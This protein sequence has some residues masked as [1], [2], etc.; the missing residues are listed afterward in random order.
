MK[1]ILLPVDFSDTC[2]NT[3]KYAADLS[4]AI[5]VDRIIL[6][7]SYYVSIYEQILPSADFVQVSAE[8]IQDNRQ[9]EEQQLLTISKQLLQKCNPGI[10]IKIASSNEPLLRAMHQ[11][12]TDEKPD[13]V[14]LGTDSSLV[15]ESHV[16]QQVVAIAKISPVPVLIVPCNAQYQAVEYALVPC[17]FA[18]VTRLNILKDL[19][20][21]HLTSNP[22]L[23]I[24]NVDPKQNHVDHEKEH[25]EALKEVLESYNYKVYYSDDHDTVK[26]I[27]NFADNHHV[28]LIIA[29]PGKHSFFYNLTHQS[30]TQ[31]LAV[32][33]HQPILILK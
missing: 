21:L 15:E 7:K 12:I 17:D 20:S 4:C 6:L 18:A 27:V 14:L 32:N 28:H 30:I 13:L 2:S 11:L 16:G 33:S 3:L 22:K 31:A 24:L 26:G 25:T 19:R 8:N 5:N 9:A 10:Q 1:T 29:L 23:L